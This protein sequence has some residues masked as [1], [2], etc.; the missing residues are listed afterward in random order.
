MLYGLITINFVTTLVAFVMIRLPFPTASFSEGL[1]IF[2]TVP[3]TLGT[4]YM[5]MGLYA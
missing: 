4:I 2:C 5:R 3:T 1:A